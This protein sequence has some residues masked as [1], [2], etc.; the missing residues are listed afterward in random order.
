MSAIARRMRALGDEIAIADEQLDRLVTQVAPTLISR[1][2]IGTQH[3]A[4]L[5]VTAGVRGH[6]KVSTGGQLRSPLVAMKSPRWW[7]REV[8]TPY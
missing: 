4:Q 6:E 1:V 7:P 3:A 8:L 5:L 2:G